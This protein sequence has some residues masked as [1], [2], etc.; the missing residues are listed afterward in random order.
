VQSADR[1]ALVKALRSV[2]LWSYLKHSLSLCTLTCILCLG[3]WAWGHYVLWVQT[4]IWH[5]T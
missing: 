5:K 3:R 2:L 4:Y 1:H